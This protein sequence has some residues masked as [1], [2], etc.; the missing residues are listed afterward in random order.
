[1]FEFFLCPVHGIFRPD[2]IMMLT[3]QANIA[4]MHLGFYLRRLNII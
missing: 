2:N 3:S 1:M 4:M